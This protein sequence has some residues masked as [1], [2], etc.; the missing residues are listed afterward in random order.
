MID[1]KQAVEAATKHLISLYGNPRSLQLEEVYLSE[2]ESSW[3][4]TLS[5]LAEA[6]EEE[7]LAGP[8][9]VSLQLEKS[10]LGKTRLVRKY[11]SFEVDRSSGEVRSMK[12][13]PVPSV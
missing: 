8:F 1:I 5:F 13:R 12:I 3:L 7:V 4:V 9:G 10:L 11:K 2:H 6:D